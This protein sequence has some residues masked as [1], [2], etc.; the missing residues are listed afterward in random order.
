MYTISENGIITLCKGDS[1]DIPLFINA[2]NTFQPYKYSLQGDDKIFFVV[3]ESFQ[4]FTEGVIRQVYTADDVNALGDVVIHIEPEDTHYLLPGRYY[5]EI[6]LLIRK[7]N[8]DVIDTLIPKRLF[9]II[10]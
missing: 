5:Y 1:A 2:G 7:D 4:P 6:K 9:Y 3:S 10:E 8:N